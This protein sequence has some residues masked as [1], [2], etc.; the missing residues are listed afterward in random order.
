LRAFLRPVALG[1]DGVPALSVSPA[2]AGRLARGQ[3][4]LLRGRDAPIMSGLVAVSCQGVLVALAEFE[5]G[6]LHPKRVFNAGA[7][8]ATR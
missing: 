3:P 4:V 7:G 5:H 1:L 8:A 2:D 6:E